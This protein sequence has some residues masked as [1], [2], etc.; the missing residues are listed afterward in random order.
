[1][2]AIITQGGTYTNNPAAMYNDRRKFG[3]SNYIAEL[4][5]TETPFLTMLMKV[6]KETVTDP[7]I[8]VFEHR[9][10]YVDGFSFY[11]S[12]NAATTSLY[13][14]SSSVAGIQYGS[15]LL[16]QKTDGENDAVSILRGGEVIQIID[17]DDVSKSAQLLLVGTP[18]TTS[19][20]VKLVGPATQG[21]VFAAG[22]PIL[23]IGKAFE[24]GS[25]K[26]AG[27]SDQLETTWHST[28]IFKTE[29]QISNTQK[30]TSTWGGNE[31]ERIRALK[32]KEHKVNIERTALFGR[33][34]SGTVANPFAA[35]GTGDLLGSSNP[36]RTTN[37][38]FPV[39]DYSS[40][41][42]SYAGSRAFKKSKS[43]YTFAQW[44]DDMEEKFEF[45]SQKK[46]T[47]CGMGYISFF[48]KMSMDEGMIQITPV[49][50]I[51]GIDVNELVSPAGR[52]VLVWDPLLRG[53][54]YKDMGATVDL[55][56]IKMI[57]L[58]GRDTSLETHIETPGDD[59]QED[60]Y[61]TEC[62]FKFMLTE[63]NSVT[64][65]Y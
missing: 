34:L 50:K 60:Q 21:F 29:Y 2:A 45:G 56:N 13:G 51:F 44:V 63:T 32:A 31:Y 9:S 55:N 28:Q 57:V 8:K 58:Q 25:A 35:P 12:E 38:L 23:V 33:R 41:L 19:C 53:T 22:D 26:T 1:M 43:T 30:A 15:K 5:P 64:R 36:L 7:D 17:T 61:L 39:C 4:T 62:G 16:Y 3:I 48:N 24:E 54:Y 37:G 20:S 47:F 46:F 49:T 52:E 27:F 65:L 11:V 40:T 42:Q 6:G 59:L 14:N 10:A 18:A